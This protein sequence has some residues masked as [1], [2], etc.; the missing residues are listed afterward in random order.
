MEKD[1]AKKL[2]VEE[3][4]ELVESK[5][6]AANIKVVQ[7]ETSIVSYGNDYEVVTEMRPSPKFYL[8]DELFI[9]LDVSV[10]FTKN[11][12]TSRIYVTADILST[13]QPIIVG[14]TSIMMDS[15]HLNLDELQ[16]D[17]FDHW[18]SIEEIEE[19]LSTFL[20]KVLADMFLGKST[21]IKLITKEE[22]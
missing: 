12:G 9:S 2:C 16:P 19:I 6:C 7:G 1:C 18:V 8:T 11:A 4:E 5:Y 22:D 13:H 17:D 20:K 21:D 14:D 15:V 10:Y 3:F